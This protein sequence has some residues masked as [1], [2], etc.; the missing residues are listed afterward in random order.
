MK[1][2][3]VFCP[4]HPVTGL[5]PMTR[6]A[7][8]ALTYPRRE[9]W[10]SYGDNPYTGFN[11]LTDARC[12]ILHN[13][14]KARDVMLAGT[15]DYLLTLE[16]DMVPPVDVIETLMSHKAEVAY[17]LYVFRNSKKW[18]AYV[19][20]KPGYGLSLSET[21][22]DAVDS[23]GEVLEVAGQGLGVTLISRKAMQAVEFHGYHGTACDGWFAIDLQAA[24]IKQ[25][26]DTNCVSGHIH[27]GAVLY[28]DIENELLYR[29]EAL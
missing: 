16:S 18:S 23:F 9:M 28:P 24:G 8:D 21:P 13:Y 5:H 1:S 7:L 6:A 2:V 10:L 17:S 22:Q 15:W 19:E 3:L 20:L 25:V 27:E 4:V 14:V 12:N 11:A 26:C 29:A